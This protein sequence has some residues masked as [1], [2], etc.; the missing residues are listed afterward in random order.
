MGTGL[1][2]GMLLSLTAAILLV[3]AGH[4][5]S[6]QKESSFNQSNK[7][8]IIWIAFYSIVVGLAVFF[9]RYFALNGISL[10]EFLISWYLGD[11]I[12]ASL[13]YRLSQKKR[14][15]AQTTVK[16]IAIVAVIS[17]LSWS[18]TFLS[19]LG[20]KF[21]P[22]MVSQSIYVISELVFPVLIGFFVFK[23]IKG[24]TRREK[25]AFV[26]GAAGAVTIGLTYRL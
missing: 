26:L 22:V 24:L 7:T 9:N 3:W 1:L 5:R 23:E 10:A 14:I 25:I 12:G 13:I 8:L 17:F 21:I 11:L 20:A 2:I 16:Q 6:K 4:N 18:T 19:Y 15:I